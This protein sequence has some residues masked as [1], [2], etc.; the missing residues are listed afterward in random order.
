MHEIA[1]VL[2]DE[3]KHLGRL[4]HIRSI[5]SRY[6]ALKLLEND[7]KVLVYELKRKSYENGETSKKTK[8]YLKF[9]K[10][11]RFS[12]YLHFFEDIAEQS[13]VFFQSDSLLVCR[14]PRK[15]DECC[16]LIDALAIAQGNA[17]NRLRNN[18]TINDNEEIVY[19]EVELIKSSGRAVLNITHT[20]EAYNE[21]FDEHLMK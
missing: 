2:K 3:F 20:P 7:Y 11:P 19:K 9:L 18:L 14:V 21:H 8:G 4:K 16:L 13:S 17:I 1:T 12:F 15:L 10:S 5:T 6:R